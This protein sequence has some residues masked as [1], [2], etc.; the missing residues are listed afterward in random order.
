M[1]ADRDRDPGRQLELITGVIEGTR[2]RAAGGGFTVLVASIDGADGET[3]LVGELAGAVE[4][5]AKVTAHGTWRDDPKFGRQFRFEVLEIMVPSSDEQ[6]VARLKTYPGVGPS[7][8]EKIVE[9][10]GALTWEVMDSSLDDLLHIPGIGKRALAKI[11]AHHSRQIGPVAKLRHKLISVRAPASLAKPIHEEFGEHAMRMLDDHPYRVSTK[12]DRFGFS[13]AER[14]ARATGVDPEDEERVEAGIIQTMRTQRN[15]GHCGIPLGALESEAA[16]FLGVRKQVLDAALERLEQR[17]L[18]RYRAELMQ[19]A[20]MDRV[21][22]RVAKA[23]LAIAMPIR[24]VWAVS[25]PEHLSPGQRDAVSAVARAGLTVLTGGPG[26]GKSTVVAAVLE[27]AESSGCEVTLCAPTGRAAKRLTEATGREASTIHR[28]LRPVPGAGSFYYDARNPLPTGLIVVDEVSMVDIELADALFSAL[29]PEHRVLLVGDADQ[30]PSVGP[31]NLLEDLIEAADH[32][33]IV[34]VRLGLVFR[35][36]HGSSIV[37]NAHRLLEGLD[38]ISDDPSLGSRGQFFCVGARTPEDA[39]AKIV[40]MAMVRIP[41]AYELESTE[42]VQILCPVHRGPVGT[43]ELNG[44]LQFRHAGRGADSFWGGSGRRFCVGD[45]VMQIRNDYERNVFNGDIGFVVEFDATF[46]V[47]DF[48]GSQKKYKRF[49]L[50][51]LRLAY[52]MTIHKSQGGEFPAVIVPVM[53]GSRMMTRNLIYTAITRAR[54]LCV[55]VGHI[56]AVSAAVKTV[57]T[58]RWTRLS[59]RLQTPE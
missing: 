3:S 20:G 5:G 53:R 6:M 32:A 58:R 51:A 34:V 44:K 16:E 36:S 1:S 46:L 21:E 59:H 41:H 30:L 19:L 29:T 55:L 17:G 26:T 7:T 39:Q 22:D 33:N 48:D 40:K 37:S 49:D 43:E 14:C 2:F 28:L 15:H 42:E 52:A 38:P 57:A 56:D 12:I 47:V 8:A 23:L 4:N 13:M 31:G 35:Q 11:R 9:Q 50:S 25:F 54:R 27:M 45:R 24:M 18:L 10:F